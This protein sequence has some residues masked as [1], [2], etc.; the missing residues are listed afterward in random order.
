MELS[1]S[2]SGVDE[3][4]VDLS[5][6]WERIWDLT[7]NGLNYVGAGMIPSLQNHLWRDWYYAWQPKVYQRR[8][9]DGGI[10]GGIGR[11]LGSYLNMDYDSEP[12]TMEF[13]YEPT[14][15]H[16]V[17]AWHTN[18]GDEII[19]MIQYPYNRWTWIPKHSH[20][21]QRMFWNNFVDDQINGGI[22][23][24]FARG[25]LPEFVVIPEG[26]VADVVQDD[27]YI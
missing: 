16:F 27:E 22:I 8:T 1:F 12:G 3:I 10:G 5:E 20:A 6:T 18:D 23:T 17:D 26:G 7:E 11:P 25:M 2:V 4:D 9:D 19:E 14:G 21:P 15:E 24:S 13:R